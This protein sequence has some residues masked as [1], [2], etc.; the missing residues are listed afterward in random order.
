[1]LGLSILPWARRTAPSYAV[2]RVLDCCPGLNPQL[3]KGRLRYATFVSLPRRFLYFE[4]PKAA[5]TTMK[6][7]LNELEGAPDIRLFQGGHRETR[8][9]M[10]IHARENS[11]LPSLA[12]LDDATQREVLESPDFLR[13][14]VVRNPYTRLLSA[15]RNKV[16]LCEPGFEHVQLAIKGRL[17][18]L[19]GKSLVSLA[20]FID[21][22]ARQAP[23][24]YD[25]HWAPQTDWNF[26]DAIGF[27]LIGRVERFGEFV[28]DFSRWLGLSETLVPPVMNQSLPSCSCSLDQPMADKLFTIYRPD[29][30]K[31]H[32]DR[33]DW[34][35][36][37]DNSE[38]AVIQEQFNDEIIER[39]LIIA[40]LY[41]QIYKPAAIQHR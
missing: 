27:R 11:C 7:L 24:A 29:F 22:V 26:F 3:V 33:A 8:R 35:P 15:W 28:A 38:P 25:P 17:P 40:Q 23:G 21:F 30:E 4:V 36:A 14:T 10:F 6:R 12:D 34:P 32:Y 41:S 5:C 1:M 2:S 37:P 20:E 18:E 39:N 31:L 19:G 16:Y 13:M 9:D